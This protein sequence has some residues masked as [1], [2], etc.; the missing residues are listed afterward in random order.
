MTG[1][2]THISICYDITLLYYHNVFFGTLCIVQSNAEKSGQ[3][4]T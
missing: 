3:S 1:S 4:V 2:N